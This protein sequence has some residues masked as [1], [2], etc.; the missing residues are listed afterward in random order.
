MFTQSYPQTL[1]FL[2]HEHITDKKEP[3]SSP[4][5]FSSFCL[6]ASLEFIY[7]LCLCHCSLHKWWNNLLFLECVH[8]IYEFQIE[9]W[10]ELI[11]PLRLIHRSSEG[12][13]VAGV[14]YAPPKRDDKI[15]PFQ[16]EICVSEILISVDLWK[17]TSALWF[18]EI[19]LGRQILKEKFQEFFYK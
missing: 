15:F 16:R 3:L 14:F 10:I 19:K 5:F 18:M 11:F 7:F 2:S 4:I 17:L 13:F 9:T 6:L 8:M 12:D 1:L